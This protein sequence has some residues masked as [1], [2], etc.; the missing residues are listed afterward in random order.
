MLDVDLSYTV[1]MVVKYIALYT[2]YVESFYHERMLILSN[3]FSA[4]IEMII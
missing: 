1:F 3:A 2:K 4:S